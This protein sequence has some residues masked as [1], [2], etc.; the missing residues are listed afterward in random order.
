MFYFLPC[1]CVLPDLCGIVRKVLCRRRI[2]TFLAYFSWFYGKILQITLFPLY[3]FAVFLA[4]FD[5]LL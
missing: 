4:G 1:L 2:C 3:F 5:N